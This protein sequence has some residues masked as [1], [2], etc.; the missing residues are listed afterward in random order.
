MESS[1]RIPILTLPEPAAK[2]AADAIANGIAEQL[3][4]AL[5]PEVAMA[6]RS[7]DGPPIVPGERRTRV[8]VAP[9]EEIIGR[10]ARRDPVEQLRR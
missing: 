6:T 8:V 2:A 7:S 5:D 9:A 4:K 1:D 10:Y 3:D